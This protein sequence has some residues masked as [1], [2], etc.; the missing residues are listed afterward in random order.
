M[1]SGKEIVKSLVI[2]AIFD[3]ALPL[4]DR[5]TK[6]EAYSPQPKHV[7]AIM[8]DIFDFIDDGANKLPERKQ[9]AKPGNEAACEENCN[10]I[11]FRD[12]CD[13]FERVER[14]KGVQKKLSL[15]FNR[16]MKKLIGNQSIFPL[17]RLLLP[18]NDNERGK[19]SLKQA[20]VSKLYVSVLGLDKK[21]SS[22]AQAL[23]NWKDPTKVQTVSGDF[24]T[25]LEHTLSTRARIE[26]SDCSIGE[27][28]SILD[29]LADAVGDAGKSA[30]IRE[31]IYPRFC[32]NEQKWLMRIVFQDLKIGLKHDTVLKYLS[33]TAVQ[34]YN[35]CTNL[36]MVC[37]EE[38]AG[39]PLHG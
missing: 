18:V 19:Y 33:P 21:H 35:Q 6:V 25:V 30:V 12:V 22:A 26:P 38:G 23:I 17:M 10:K 27:V 36:K 24:G 11:L 3:I 7:S 31:K 8:D 29:S 1:I 4:I 2:K 32:A 15:V 39:I 9:E 37:E 20:T 5:S 28:N 34:R 13:L 16:N 14:T